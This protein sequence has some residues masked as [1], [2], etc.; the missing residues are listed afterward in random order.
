MA[1]TV[2]EARVYKNDGRDV[3]AG[4]RRQAEA[5]SRERE[6]AE[7]RQNA[8]AERTAGRN[9]NCRRNGGGTQN[10]VERRKRCETVK[11]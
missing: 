10:Q 3:R 4:R 5:G 8:N 2:N 1:K 7:R 9:G 6:T 11:T